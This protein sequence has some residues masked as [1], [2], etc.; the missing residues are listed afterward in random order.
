[1]PRSH[2]LYRQLARVWRLSGRWLPNGWLDAIRQLALFAGAYYLYRLVRG[3]VDGQAGLAFENARN[4][5]HFERSVGLFFEPG[6][7]AWARGQDWILTWANWMY[8]NSHFVVTTT[9]LIWL[10]IAR[11]HAYYYV[12]NMFMV[13]MTLA[14]A[15][16]LVY[17]TAPP[18]FLPEWGFTDTVA[19]F[20]GDGASNSASVLY[21]PFAAVP[22]MHVAFALM[23]AVPAFM[24]V[25]NRLLKAFWAIYPALVTFV[26][27]ATANH[28]WMDAALGA[29]VAAASASAASYAFARARP[30]GLGVPHGE[31][32][33]VSD[34]LDQRTRRAR[35]NGRSG[36]LTAAEMRAV[37]RNRLIESRLTPN[38]ISL[39]GLVGNLI[40][41]ALILNHDFV[42]A[43]VAFILGSLCDMFDGRYSRMSGKGTPVRRLPRLHARPHRGGRGAGRGRLVVRRAGRRGRGRARRCS[44]SSARTWSPTPAPAP[45]RSAWSAR[46]GLRREP[47][48]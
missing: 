43:G 42:L 33:G 27:M 5:V 6:L 46:S 25:R 30:G 21:N 26:V 13:A 20:V 3:F 28:F 8:V 11:N 14:L 40:A 1:M 9:F 45:R 39:T 34:G 44:P 19:Q 7:Q 35:G 31:G 15:G 41:A 23:I 24:L 47:S 48:G 12:R 4:L 32:L 38:A 36:S 29:L 18:R 2:P 37:A 16:Y 10:Y 22:S 17:P